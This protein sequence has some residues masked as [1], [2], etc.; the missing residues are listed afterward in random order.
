[1]DISST[2]R[3]DQIPRSEANGFIWVGGRQERQKR[4]DMIDEGGVPW[5]KSDR[6]TFLSNIQGCTCW[7]VNDLMAIFCSERRDSGTK[8]TMKKTSSRATR[9]ARITTASSL[10]GEEQK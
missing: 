8:I 1:M 2:L 4:H 5:S 3:S 7:K 10:P 9:E 6:H